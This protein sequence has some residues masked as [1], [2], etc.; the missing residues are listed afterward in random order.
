MMAGNQGNNRIVW[1]GWQVSYLKRHWQQM[2]AQQ[3]ADRLGMTQ[4]IVRMKL[5]SM[6]LKKQEMEYWTPA[7]VRCLK[8]HYRTIGDTEL[9][10][11]FA[12]RWKKNKG[13]SKKHIE[14][15]RRYLGLKRTAKEI[16]AIQ[17]RN[18]KKGRFAE[19]PVKAWKVRGGAAPIGER[20][21]W[22]HTGY[23][24]IVIKTEKGFR[25]YARWL[26]EDTYGKIKKGFKV[27]TL[28]GDSLDI[29]ID[30]LELVSGARHAILN[31]TGT[32]G[33]EY[34]RNRAKARIKS[35]IK[36]IEKANEKQTKRLK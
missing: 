30:N 29:R 8:E 7:Q 24:V 2:T 18:V 26:W 13:W 4:T 5:Y 3:L 22:N 19:C 16:K 21:V 9:A 14:K 25:H 12:K 20:R 11:M 33:P 1:R 10:E 6:G 27:R 32:C 23:P 17:L 28:N 35:L 15:K 34:K 36:Q 31:K